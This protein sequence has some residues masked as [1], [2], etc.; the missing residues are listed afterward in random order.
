MDMSRPAWARGLKLPDSRHPALYP[1]SRP[2]WARGLKLS[3][4]PI[5]PP[6]I[7]RALRGRVD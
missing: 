2:A 6:L 4:K 3:E 5:S 1:A 7:R